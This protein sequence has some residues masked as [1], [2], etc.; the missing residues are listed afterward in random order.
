VPGAVGLV[1]VI[2]KIVGLDTLA[3]D[4]PEDVEELSVDEEAMLAGEEVL[5]Q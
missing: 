4:S 5:D 1:R 3:I 2:G